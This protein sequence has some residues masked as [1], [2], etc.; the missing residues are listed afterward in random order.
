V[1]PEGLREELAAGT[2][3]PV[4]LV[5]GEEPL[6]RDDALA[7]LRAA[8]LADGPADFNSERLEGAATSPAA[9]LDAVH[10]LPVMAQRRLVVL[11]D[12]EAARAGQRGLLEAVAEV[13][14]ELREGSE[15]VLVVVA[16]RV[17][18]RA[19]WVKAFGAE[20]RVDCDPPRRVREVAAFA[21]AEAKRQGVDLEPGAAEL[22]AERVGPQLLMLR[23]EIA[24][25]ALLAGPGETVSRAHVGVGTADVAE[26]P[27]WDLTDAIGEGRGADALA[28]LAKLLRAGAPAPVVLGALASHF[29]RL[30]RLRAGGGVAAAPF[31]RRKLES[32][33]GRYSE[34]RL[35]ACLRAIHQ[36]DLSLKGA[37]GLRPELALER[38]VMGLSL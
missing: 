19:R 24:K 18:G 36:T 21:R 37:G 4:Y 28:V 15:T 20:A 13:V 7:A 3:R 10:T 38:L 11:R 22:L 6:L 32:Q 23:Q 1:T 17:D 16:S 30:L 14:A 27:I 9:L 5:V 33:A 26:E 25:A 2:L 12:P 31:V 34:R 29:R 35:L 8:V